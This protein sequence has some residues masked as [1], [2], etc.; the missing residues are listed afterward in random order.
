MTVATEIFDDAG[1][2]WVPECSDAFIAQASYAGVNV[3]R[4]VREEPG[5]LVR[6]I[7]GDARTRGIILWLSVERQADGQQVTPQMFAKLCRGRDGAVCRVMDGL[8]TLLL[9][10]IARRFP[11]SRYGVAT[12][13]KQQSLVEEFL[14]SR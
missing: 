8:T 11:H 13:A 1:H 7:T 6:A 5:A 4:L 12:L 14:P 9:L 10:A 3:R 2:R